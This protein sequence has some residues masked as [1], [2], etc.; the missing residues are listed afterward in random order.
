[1]CKYCFPHRSWLWFSRGWIFKHTRAHFLNAPQD[2][3][4]L[5]RTPA[6]VSEKW[7]HWMKNLVYIHTVSV[8]ELKG[9]FQD[10]LGCSAPWS[11]YGRHRLAKGSAIWKFGLYLGFAHRSTYPSM[12]SVLFQ[13]DWS[14]PL[15]R[16]LYPV[17]EWRFSWPWASRSLGN[18]KEASSA[19]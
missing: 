13:I 4:G 15:V 8:K 2:T 17:P 11:T 1:M 12:P 19:R 3:P 9:Q 6:K 7:R 14:I 18:A 10:F 5:A 16:S